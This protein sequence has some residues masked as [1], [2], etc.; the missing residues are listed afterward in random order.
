MLWN[1]EEDEILSNSKDE[2]SNEYKL[3]VKIKGRENV[4]R[5]IKYLEINFPKIND[6]E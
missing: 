5:R 2:N 3:L 1:D 4:E 6:K